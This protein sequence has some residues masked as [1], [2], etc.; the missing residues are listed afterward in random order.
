M[1]K[2]LLIITVVSSVQSSFQ[3][4][5]YCCDQYH[6]QGGSP[7]CDGTVYT[8]DNCGSVVGQY[9]PFIHYGGGH[10]PSDKTCKE[11]LEA[12][13][14]MCAP[15][16]SYNSVTEKC[17]PG[18]YCDDSVDNSDTSIAIDC[19]LSRRRLNNGRQL[20]DC[21]VVPV[22][23]PPT[24]PPP[25]PPPVIKT[26]ADR[27]PDSFDIE[28]GCCARYHGDAA[29]PGCCDENEVY[30]TACG[31][32]CNEDNP[33]VHWGGAHCMEET[34]TFNRTCQQCF[35]SVQIKCAAGY[36]LSNVTFVCEEGGLCADEYSDADAADSIPIN[37]AY[38]R[39]LSVVEGHNNETYKCSQQPLT[40]PPNTPPPTSKSEESIVLHD[41]EL[42][43]IIVGC[44]LGTVA[45]MVVYRTI[46][47][48]NG[49]YSPVRNAEQFPVMGY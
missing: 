7:N 10:C 38:A 24:E 12:A 23:L 39:R 21:R 2:T 27:H 35:D 43:G 1:L 15:G 32:V 49:G 31:K 13:Q 36:S 29:S 28:D 26:D 5:Y 11:C 46:R 20:V 3:D 40:L 16:F 19:S 17:E 47:G 22:T 18:G 8:Y 48:S 9:N 37:C 4:A 30:D 45:L 34:E 6:G 41:L 42:A 33:L 44:I 25:P 14:I